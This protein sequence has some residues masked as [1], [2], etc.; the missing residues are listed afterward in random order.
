MF[1]ESLELEAKLVKKPFE[2]RNTNRTTQTLL[3]RM[4]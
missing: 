4:F 1:A 3:P 2:I